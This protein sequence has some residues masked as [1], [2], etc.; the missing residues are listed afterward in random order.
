[1]VAAWLHDLV[2][3]SE[4]GSLQSP[5]YLESPGPTVLS[6]SAYGVDCRVV[7]RVWHLGSHSS[8]EHAPAVHV[9]TLIS[10]Y[11]A[12]PSLYERCQSECPDKSGAAHESSDSCHCHNRLNEASVYE[13]NP[14]LSVVASLWSMRSSRCSSEIMVFL[15]KVKFWLHLAY[16]SV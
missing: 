15:A 6:H 3:G 16:D 2:G 10:L 11:N 12:R 7:D 1:M 5:A 4:S 14:A 8:I 9:R 13:R